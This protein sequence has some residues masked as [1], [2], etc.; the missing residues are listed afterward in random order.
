MVRPT[1]Q[2]TIVIEKIICYSPFTQHGEPLRAALGSAMKHRE[3]GK[4]T[5]K[6]LD[7]G[8]Y[9]KAQAG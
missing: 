3:Q 1:D 6:R 5:G 7:G 4:R 8:F 2:E 9:V